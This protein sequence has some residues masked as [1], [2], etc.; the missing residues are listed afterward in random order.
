MK[1]TSSSYKQ[2][3]AWR[4]YWEAWLRAS[5]PVVPSERE[6]LTLADRG[7]YTRWLWD[8]IVSHGWHHCKIERTSGVEQLW[9]AMALAQLW[10]ISLGCQVDHY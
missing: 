6:M 10:R 1:G 5:G 8:A 7:P 3:G 4:P 9:L 2:P